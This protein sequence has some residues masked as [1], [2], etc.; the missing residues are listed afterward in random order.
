MTAAPGGD[1]AGG[2]RTAVLGPLAVTG[3]A[4]PLQPRH[5]ELVVALALAGPAGVTGESLRGMLGAG[6]DLP[7][8]PPSLRQLITRARRQL[9]PAPSGGQY[10]IHR[11]NSVYALDP[12]AVLDW[13]EFRTLAGRGRAE[14][15]RGPLRAAL[16]LLRGQ[17]LS[18][19]YYW[20]LETAFLDTVRAAVTSAAVALAALELAAGDPAAA[21][22]AARAGLAA[23]DGSEE[24]WR[25]L[26]RAQDAAGNT[27]GVRAAW[28]GCQAAAR[29][30]A[31]GAAPHPETAVLYRELTGRCHAAGGRG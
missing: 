14:R 2:L 28:R 17:P 15:D 29:D 4:A 3:T 22:D 31:P 10:V 5:A 30:A 12:A 25:L 9:G 19:L 6:P 13:D 16:G 23:G 8:E 21:R 24:L 7:R 11:G 18:G 26:M 20:W 27:A 1:P